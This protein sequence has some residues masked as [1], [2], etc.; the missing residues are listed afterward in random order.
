VRHPVTL[1]TFDGSV[2]HRSLTTRASRQ[3]AATSAARTTAS[4]KIRR[5]REGAWWLCCARYAQISWR[6]WLLATAQVPARS[7]WWT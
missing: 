1:A 4:A 6:P 7:V 2:A 3:S 5:V